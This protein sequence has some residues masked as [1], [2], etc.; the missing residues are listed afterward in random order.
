MGAEAAMMAIQNKPC[1]GIHTFSRALSE[2]R[3][4]RGHP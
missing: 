4:R 2:W 3:T 1:G